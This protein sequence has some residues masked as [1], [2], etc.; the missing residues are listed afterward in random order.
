MGIKLKVNLKGNRYVNKSRMTDK[1]KKKTTKELKEQIIKVQKNTTTKEVSK[2]NSM[3]LGSHNYYKMATLSSLDFA[4]IKFLVMKTLKCRLRQV[5]N[6]RPKISKTFKKL[7][8]DY[9]G[10]YFTVAEITIFPIGKCKT[11]PPMNFSQD[12]CNFT[13][14]GRVKQHEK[15]K[16]FNHLIKYLLNNVNQNESTEYNDNRISL[17]AGQ[18]GKCYVTGKKLE[19]GDMEC[20]HKK[21]KFLGGT[22]EYKNLLWVKNGVHKLIHCTKEETIEKYM[23]MLNLDN[24]GL[25]RVNSLRKLVGNSVI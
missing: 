9:N 22:D 24:K 2:L 6:K 23:K 12:I 4:E 7:Y 16:G 3:I 5:M 18:R 14:E 10:K 21:P 25:K 17:I 8:G 1:A 11:D 15:L 13:E 19:I 20:H